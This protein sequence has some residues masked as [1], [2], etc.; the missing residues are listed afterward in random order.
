M[1][2]VHTKS[3]ISRCN[4]K[5]FT[6]LDCY[7]KNGEEGNVFFSIHKPFDEPK[8]GANVQWR[9][10]LTYESHRARREMLSFPWACYC[11]IRC[12]LFLFL[13]KKFFLTFIFERERDRDRQ[14]VSGGGTEREGDTESEAGSRL[15]AVSTEPDVGL[16]SQSV[17]SWPELKS[18]AQPTELPR[19]PGGNFFRTLKCDGKKTAGSQLLT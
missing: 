3:A 17:R 4:S 1:R 12:V 9:F 10:C 8:K 16:N 13:L 11:V 2:F 6:F 19:H 18:N 15:W 5:L 7:S 14:S